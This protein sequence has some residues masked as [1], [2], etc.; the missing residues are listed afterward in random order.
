MEGLYV[1]NPLIK[2]TTGEMGKLYKLTMAHVA[3]FTE[4]TP[5]HDTKTA[6]H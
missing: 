2:L 5:K 6:L 1:G 4:T 3:F